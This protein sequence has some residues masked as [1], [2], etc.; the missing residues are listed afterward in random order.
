MFSTP[1]GGDSPM[2]SRKKKTLAELKAGDLFCMATLPIKVDRVPVLEVLPGDN[3]T[4]QKVRVGYLNPTG[5]MTVTNMD[6]NVPVYRFTE[7]C[8]DE[9]K[10]DDLF[11]MPGQISHERS[12]TPLQKSAPFAAPDRP[13]TIAYN[14][15]SLRDRSPTMFIPTL[16][17]LKLSEE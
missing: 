17:V 8:F 11:G 15:V 4:V 1:T 2:Q 14:A 10:A 6:G 5:G 12:F 13:A 3:P 7:K 16:R 9:L